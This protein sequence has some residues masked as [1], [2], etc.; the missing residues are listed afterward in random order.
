L[1]ELEAAVIEEEIVNPK[2]IGWL[3]NY[4]RKLWS[5]QVP[6][7]DGSEDKPLYPDFVVFRR[8]G[9]SVV[10]D[11]IDPHRAS[12]TDAWKKAQGLATFASQHGDL[13][14][15]IEIVAKDKHGSTK[16]IDVNKSLL[17]GKVRRLA[18]SDSWDELLEQATTTAAH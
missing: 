8:T 3:R 10:A 15:R 17:Q 5:L 7:D 1:N 11:I 2:T 9:D 13:F 16:R 14:G 12:L 4:D 6:Y 18:N